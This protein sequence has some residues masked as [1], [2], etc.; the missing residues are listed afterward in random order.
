MPTQELD[1]A[2]LGDQLAAGPTQTIN[3][4]PNNNSLVP[5]AGYSA[6]AKKYL[7]AWAVK[8]NGD[9]VLLRMRDEQLADAPG[10][11]DFLEIGYA[12][13][14]AGG[15]KDFVVA[16]DNGT[17]QGGPPGAARVLP[18]GSVSVRG[19]TNTGGKAARYTWDLVVRNGQPVLIWAEQ[20]GSGPDLWIDA[21]CDD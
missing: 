10:M 7:F 11:L 6:S 14:I 5:A 17:Q 9:S 2:L 19:V 15:D 20:G 3:A 8:H 4:D 12:P 16:W 18:D 21:L 1:A 13:K